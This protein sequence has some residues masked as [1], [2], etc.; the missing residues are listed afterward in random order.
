M[1]TTTAPAESAAVTVAPAVESAA[2]ITTSGQQQADPYSQQTNTDKPEWL[3]EKFWRNDAPDVESLAKSYQG[4]EQ[5]LGKKAQAILPPN[6]KSTPEEIAAFRKAL[7][8]PD[9][10]EGYGLA[11]PENMRDDLVWD[12]N[13]AKEVSAIAHRHNIPAAALKELVELDHKR[14]SMTSEAAAQMVHQ[15]LQAGRQELQR[16]YGEQLDNK[17]ELAKRAAA[18]VGVDPSS[19]G[20]IDPNVVK[21]FI[22]LAE[23]LSDDRLVE[24]SAISAS[25]GRARAKDIATNPSNPLYNRYHEGDAEI[26]DQ[27]RRMIM[28][29]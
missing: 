4:L 13:I 27:V 15:Q 20:F 12:D 24:G 2:V 5:L 16:V 19:Q 29:G 28:Q 17:I 14:A 25:S 26:V 8:V 10:P 22:A 6:E 3:P 1:D 21:G 11:K 18:T 23:K 7:G 9:S